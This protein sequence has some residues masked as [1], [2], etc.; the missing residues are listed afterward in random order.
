LDY[1]GR[2]DLREVLPQVAARDIVI[3]HGDRDRIIASAQAYFLRDRLG[4]GRLVILPGAG[5]VPMVSRSQELNALLAE[6]L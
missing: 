2:Q 6:F 3:V 4:A 1:L 5:H